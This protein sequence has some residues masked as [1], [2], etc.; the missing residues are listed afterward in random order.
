MDLKKLW[1]EWILPFGLEIIIVL[2][3]MTIMNQFGADDDGVVL[4]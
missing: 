1:K 2:L 3:I 4:M